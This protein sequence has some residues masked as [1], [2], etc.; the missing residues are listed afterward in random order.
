MFIFRQI[1]SK[2]NMKVYLTGNLSFKHFLKPFR[3]EYT[4]KLTI[5]K[6]PFYEK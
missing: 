5:F 6:K 2:G 1:H 3:Y 4:P